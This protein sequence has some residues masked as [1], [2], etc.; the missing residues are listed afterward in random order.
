[1]LA[2]VASQPVAEGSTL[3][4]Q[5]AATD[6]DLPANKFTYALVQ[7]P[8]GLQVDA[9]TGRL[10]WTPS[11][12]QGPSTQTIIVSV[13]DD[14]S[15]P[16]E[17][18]TTFRVTVTESNQA[19]VIGPVADQAVTEGQRLVFDLAGS[20]PDIPANVIRYRLVSPPTGMQI[21]AVTGRVTWTPTTDQGPASYS[22]IA[23]VYDNGEPSLSGRRTF[24][25]TV[26]DS[27]RAPVAAGQILS[28]TEEVAFSI[29]LSAT[30]AD[31]DALTYSIATQPSKGKLVGFP[32]NLTYLPNLNAFGSDVFTFKANDGTVDS[33]PATVSITL[34]G[35]NDPPVAQGGQVSLSEDSPTALTLLASDPDED[36]LV[37]TVV[38]APQRGVLSGT[39]PNLVYTP[40]S[41]VSGPDQIVFKVSDGRTESAPA[42][43]NITI[44]PVNDPPV[45]AVIPVQSVPEETQMILDLSASDVDLPAQSISF[46]LVDGP[47]GMAVSPTGRITWTP[48]EDQ[49]P[50]TYSVTVRASDGVGSGV[51]TFQVRV[52]EVNAAPVIPAIPDQSVPEGDLLALDVPGSDPDLPAQT[53][54]F[55]LVSGPAGMGITAQGRLTWVPP[56]GLAATTQSVRVRVSDG[57]LTAE[58]SFRVT[59]SERVLRTPPVFVGLTNAVVPENALYRQ[60]LKGFDESGRMESLMFTLVQGPNGSSVRDGV[61]EWKPSESQGPANHGVSVAVSNGGLS[62]TNEF[63][64]KVTEVNE[65]PSWPS[66][67]D[68]TIPETSTYSLKLRAIDVDVPAQPLRYLMLEGPE[69]ARLAEDGSFTWTPTERQG[70]SVR[71]VRIAVTDGEAEASSSF[72]ITVEESN[73][74]P[75][76][77]GLEDVTLVGG[78]PYTQVLLGADPDIP[79]QPLQ[80]RWIE[81][82]VGSGVTNGVFFWTPGT[83][84]SEVIQTAAL[85]VSDGLVSVTNRFNLRLKPASGGP[86]FVGLANAV[87]P[88]GAPYRQVFRATH[89]QLPEAALVMRLI[90]GPS[91][92]VL[93]GNALVWTPVEEQ[94][95][96]TYPVR[97]S[98]SD[99]VNAVTNGFVLVV[100]EVNAPP[101]FTV[102]T[103][104]VIPELVASTQ[105]LRYSDADLPVQSLNPRLV[106]GPVGARI[107]GDTFSWTPTEAQGPGTNVILVAV[108]DGIESVT[109]AFTVVV[110]EVPTAPSLALMVD[111]EVPESA[112][113]VWAIPGVDSDLP[114]QVLTYRMLEGP[115]GSVLTNGVFAWTPSETDGGS[116]AVL[117]VAVSDGNTSV[118]NRVTLTVLE[119][120]R[121]PVPTPM[122]TRRVS[123][124]NQ[125]AFTV[126]STDADLPAQR[127][128]YTAVSVPAGMTV[129]S[130]GVVSWRP[131]EAQGPSTNVVLVR[132]TDDGKPAL[133]A[134]NAIEIVVRE[135]NTVPVLAAVGDATVD[136]M[137]ELRVTLSASDSDLPSQ[138]LVYRLVTS[139]P[140]M[141][142]GAGGELRWIPTMQQAGRYPVTVSVGDGLANV[143]RSFT[144]TVRLSNV[145][146]VLTAV[147]TRRVSEG[148]LLSFA[149]SATDADVPAQRLVYGLVQGPEGLA[150]G[151]NGVVNWRPTEA[152]GPSTNV[153]LVRVTDDGKPA[154]SATNSIEIVV[155]E[156]NLAPV[157]DGISNRTVKLPGGVALSLKATDVDL[158]VQVLTFGLVAG[159]TGMTVGNDG[160]L[161]WT[162]TESQARSTNRV[163]VSVSDGTAKVETS[164]EVVVE[165]SPRLALRV[166]GSTVTLQVA[167]PPGATCRLEQAD[168]VGGPWTAVP[169]VNDIVTG[170]FNAPQPVILPGPLQ[171][172]RL[173][174]LR[175]L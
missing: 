83:L 71:T 25:V 46:S 85:A 138:P 121:A 135:V 43:I 31:G 91:G 18:R 105:V 11:E 100:Q 163:T 79:A 41:D 73:Q 77:V 38:G 144:V 42:T 119:V 5:L 60:T 89:P 175:V 88:E 94:G 54:T 104:A 27:N 53:L 151:T 17:S 168:T 26:M 154:L 12:D 14:A 158:P 87:I 75:A 50:S 98:V 1:M 141:T 112:D 61:F 35:V 101:V 113:F 172:G 90:S 173:Y 103:N 58:G 159:P 23:E 78:V 84:S 29:R 149:L 131:T 39:A 166:E 9:A 2:S 132:V 170:G 116:Q 99:G 6:A 93:Q 16:L 22:V 19:P 140:G 30:D 155:R 68:A 86:S 160:A 52:S 107:V 123:E 157:L 124:G 72:T 34:A 7:G 128:L 161:R 62:T 65:A 169:G 40:N 21:D 36:L 143:E 3:S 142:L 125:L 45:I 137:S 63:F 133:S 28:G 55:T 67:A 74:M 57:L 114:V 70:P 80:F 129:S 156:V 24:Q 76:F 37:Y 81:G 134:T 13:T 111:R 139:P 44:R 32:P 51:R 96:G 15:T 127:L 64:I 122:G 8:A 47:T 146:P 150:V 95:P 110:R 97:V 4:I 171:T 165:A 92:A 117:S 136:T 109:N 130:N 118:T 106:S 147:G 148:N 48:A 120:N 108:S 82:P 153:V 167:G 102:P 33:L 69:G 152:Q 174:R 164:F 49:G 56:L 115:V 20:D 10:E 66:I 162:P 126:L 59:V 145:A